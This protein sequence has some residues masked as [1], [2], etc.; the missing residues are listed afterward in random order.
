MS[1]K[2]IRNFDYTILL[3][4]KM[5]ETRAF[6]KEWVRRCSLCG[7]EVRGSHGMTAPLHPAPRLS[8]WHS[9]SP[10]RPSTPAMPSWSPKA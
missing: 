7:R 3:C 8:S 1:I 2:D 6:Y 10:L 9:A 5:K 4:R